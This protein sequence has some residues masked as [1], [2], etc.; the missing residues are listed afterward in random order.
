M[1]SGSKTSVKLLLL[2]L[3]LFL[4]SA[5]FALPDSC[6]DFQKVATP[7][8]ALI[9]QIN[10]FKK[11]KPTAAQACS[12]L[13]RLVNSEAKILN[14]MNANKDWCQIPD[15]QIVGLKQASGQSASFKAQAC[16]A[17]A[18]QSKQIAQMRRQQQMQQRQQQ[19]GGGGQAP[20][21]GVKL[22]QGAL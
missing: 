7:R 6:N 18:Q 19:S 16:N 13:T 22:P 2:C 21:A 17:A 3:A 11:R 9:S 15:D 1:S 12:I 10:G 14:W 20:G 4:P 8:M 5:A